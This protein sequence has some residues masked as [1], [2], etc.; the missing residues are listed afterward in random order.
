MRRLALRRHE[1]LAA[2]GRLAAQV[3]HEVRNPLSTIGLAARACS[4]TIYPEQS[5]PEGWLDQIRSEAARLERVTQAY[6]QMARLPDPQAQETLLA[7]LVGD[8][9][10]FLNDDRLSCGR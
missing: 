7:P 8:L 6:L 10:R 9:I 1:R 3:V 4:A 5:D 2:T